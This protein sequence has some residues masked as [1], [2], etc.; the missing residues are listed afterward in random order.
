MT[1]TYA[2]ERRSSVGVSVIRV[3]TFEGLHRTARK[4]MGIRWV[5]MLPIEP[6]LIDH[7]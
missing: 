7:L 6:Y 1:N 2:E 3:Q 4:A 5:T